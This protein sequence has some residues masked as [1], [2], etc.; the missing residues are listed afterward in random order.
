MAS[1]VDCCA[2]ARGGGSVRP[3]C[4]LPPIP[5]PPSPIHRQTLWLHFR[6]VDHRMLAASLHVFCTV[7]HTQRLLCPCAASAP[8]LLQ[9]HDNYIITPAASTFSAPTANYR[10]ETCRVSAFSYRCSCTGPVHNCLLP[11]YC[12]RWLMSIFVITPFSFWRT[13]FPPQGSKAYLSLGQLTCLIK[14]E[15]FPASIQSLNY[16]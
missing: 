3:S 11:C 7:T 12:I 15:H 9:R 4:P 14:T 13:Q 6:L 16:G 5:T 8:L 10:D 2:Q 1:G